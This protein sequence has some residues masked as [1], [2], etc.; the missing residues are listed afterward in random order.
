MVIQED[1]RPLCPNSNELIH[2]NL[3]YTA[4]GITKSLLSSSM[5][6]LTLH[7][8]CQCQHG[9]LIIEDVQYMNDK[10]VFKRVIIDSRAEQ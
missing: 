7:S 3:L 2:M 6:A 5:S 9:K 4:P 8:G 10:T 1:E